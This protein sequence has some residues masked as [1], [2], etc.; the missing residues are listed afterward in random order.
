MAWVRLCLPWISSIFR[1]AL[2]NPFNYTT[3]TRHTW[4]YIQYVAFLIHTRIVFYVSRKAS[5]SGCD[6]FTTQFTLSARCPVRLLCCLV[7]YWSY[8]WARRAPSTCSR[9]NSGWWEKI[10]PETSTSSWKSPSGFAAP[11]IYRF[12]YLDLSAWGIEQHNPSRNVLEN[13]NHN[14]IFSVH[15]ICFPPIKLK[16]STWS[17]FFDLYNMHC[18]FFQGLYICHILPLWSVTPSQNLR[19]I[20]LLVWIKSRN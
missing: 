1:S 17:L 2:L 18:K 8:S 7:R 9:L 6:S 11:A 19:W 20:N 14:E 5:R 16:G 13:D 12:A 10:S 4:I 3:D 15:V